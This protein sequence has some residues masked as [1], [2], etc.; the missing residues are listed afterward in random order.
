MDT[1]RHGQAVNIARQFAPGHAQGRTSIAVAGITAAAKSTFARAL[2]AALSGAGLTVLYASLD[3]FHHPA[4]IRNPQG[5][6][7]ATAYYEQAH[8]LPAVIERLLQPFMSGQPRVQLASHDL[9]R[10]AAV[11][12]IPVAVPDNCC[13]VVDGTFTLKPEL[14]RFWAASVWLATPFQLAAARGTRRDAASLG[15]LNVARRRYATRYHAACWRYLE[16]CRPQDAATWV[17]D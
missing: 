16:D 2:A 13:M 17:V 1:Q 14:R 4:D 6:D 10:D 9:E 7:T 8:D 12:P 15:G 11:D 3:D 5:L